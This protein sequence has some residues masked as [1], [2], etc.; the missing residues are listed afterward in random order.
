MLGRE[1]AASPH[2]ATLLGLSEL[3]EVR[4]PISARKHNTKSTK[5]TQ[6]ST[7]YLGPSPPPVDSGYM[8]RKILTLQPLHCMFPWKHFYE[9]SCFN[10]IQLEG[11]KSTSEANGT[12]S[13]FAKPAWLQLD[14]HSG[15][16]CF[17]TKQHCVVPGDLMGWA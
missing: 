7:F 3:Q 2:V 6:R 1:G 14:C 15:N 12:W 5:S 8:G 10:A 13:F 9:T 11:K 17:V 16:A 4:P